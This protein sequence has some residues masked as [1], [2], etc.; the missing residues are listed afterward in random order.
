MATTRTTT[1]YCDTCHEEITDIHG[2]LL[3]WKDVPTEVGFQSSDFR[4]VHK[5]GKCDYDNS[6][7]TWELG[8]ALGT[9]GLARLLYFPSIGSLRGPSGPEPRV[10]NMDQ[11]VDII[12][13][14]QTPQYEEARRYFGTSEVREEFA[15]ANEFLPYTQQGLAAII[16]IGRDAE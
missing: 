12:R 10:V 3:A 6:M 11:F 13:R 7:A 1:R 14:L 5:G 2:A 4:I 16:E 15:D 9:D 8:Y